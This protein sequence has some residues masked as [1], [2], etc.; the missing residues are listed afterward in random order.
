MNIVGWGDFKVLHRSRWIGLQRK[1]HC[2]WGLGFTFHWPLKSKADREFFGVC[3]WGVSVT[4]IS[5]SWW[6]MYVLWVLYWKDYQL[7]DSHLSLIHY[8][9]KCNTTVCVPSTPNVYS[10]GETFESH[11]CF[12]GIILGDFWQSHKVIMQMPLCC[13]T[14]F[15]SS[16]FS[17]SETSTWYIIRIRLIIDM[18][19]PQVM[20]IT[21]L[22]MGRKVWSPWDIFLRRKESFLLLVIFLI[23]NLQA[24]GSQV[25]QRLLFTL[26]DTIFSLLHINQIRLPYDEDEEEASVVQW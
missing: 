12:T 5:L 22:K 17:F 3:K 9:V 25:F 16:F 15:R 6:Q 4:V 7:P 21:I 2:V 14:Q 19:H 10:W 8:P 18:P 20:G 13:F 11:C 1:A 24:C 26:Q 23:V